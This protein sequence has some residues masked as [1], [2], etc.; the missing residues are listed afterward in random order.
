MLKKRQPSIVIHQRLDSAIFENKFSTIGAIGRTN[1]KMPVNKSDMWQPKRQAAT[2][3]DFYKKSKNET[4]IKSTIITKQ[5]MSRRSGSP[6]L[7]EKKVGSNNSRIKDNPK[8][9]R[10]VSSKTTVITRD[11]RNRQKS[12]DKNSYQTITVNVRSR[13]NKIN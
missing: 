13:R 2:S 3:S 6:Q 12:Q 5:I 4:K 8:T 1:P 10:E 7:N 9:P 11:T